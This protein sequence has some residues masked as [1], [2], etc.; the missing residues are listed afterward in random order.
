M[1]DVNMA[2][3]RLLVEFLRRLMEAQAVRRMEAETITP[4]EAERL[5][6]TLLRS[7]DAVVSLCEKLGVAPDSLNLDLGPLGRLM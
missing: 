3:T 7:R 5:G 1:A 4:E 2:P 6:L